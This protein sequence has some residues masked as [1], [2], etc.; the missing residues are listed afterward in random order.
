MLC[1]A[2]LSSGA[3]INTFLNSTI[4]SEYSPLWANAIPRLFLALIKDGLRCRTPLYSYIA[5]SKSRLG[6]NLSDR[7]ILQ[8]AIKDDARNIPKYFTPE[9]TVKLIFTSPPYYNLKDYSTKPKKQENQTKIS[10][11]NSRQGFIL[12]FCL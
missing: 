10:A 7:N 4:A 12:P 9:T 8:L 1:F 2:S 6:L 3:V 11:K 5:L